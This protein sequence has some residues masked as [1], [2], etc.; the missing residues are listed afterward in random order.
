MQGSNKE[1]VDY[2]VEEHLDGAICLLLALLPHSLILQPLH[3]SRRL[4]TA[5]EKSREN[6]GGWNQFGTSICSSIETAAMG[7]MQR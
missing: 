7:S 3:D 6:H 1:T 2:H 4:E 5:L